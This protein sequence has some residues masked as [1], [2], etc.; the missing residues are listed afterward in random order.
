[1]QE[2][3]FMALPPPSRSNGKKRGIRNYSTAQHF[4]EKE[5]S[6]PEKFGI[7]ACSRHSGFFPFLSNGHFHFGGGGWG[8][9]K[10]G[11]TRRRVMSPSGTKAK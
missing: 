2:E 4:P 8:G 9:S 1:M 7:S 5:N 3:D 10:V 6:A 11:I